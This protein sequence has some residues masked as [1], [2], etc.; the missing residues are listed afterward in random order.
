MYNLLSINRYFDIKKHFHLADNQN[1][2][3]G[4]KMSKVSPLYEM[5]NTILIQFGVFHE[6]LSVDESMVSYFGRHSAK[7]FIRGKPIRYGY[8]IWSLCGIDGYS[9]HLK[10]LPRKRAEC[11]CDHTTGTFRYKSHQYNGWH[12]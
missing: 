11:E 6:I 9:Y 5:I 7:M 8:K 10:N 3:E 12:Y 2:T 4:D 1:L